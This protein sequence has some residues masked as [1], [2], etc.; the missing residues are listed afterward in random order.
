MSI[1]HHVLFNRAA[2]DSHEATRSM[3]NERWM[4]PPLEGHVEQRIHAEIAIVP[5]LDP[6]TAIHVRQNFE[7]V[8]GN[9]VET[10]YNFIRSVEAALKHPKASALQRTLGALTAQ[11]VE[12]QIPYVEEGLTEDPLVPSLTRTRHLKRGTW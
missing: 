9:H 10:M 12:L 7:P 6:T 11:A 3:R 8:E 5:L 1:F 2:W 4:I